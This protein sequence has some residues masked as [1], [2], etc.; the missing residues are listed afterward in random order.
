LFAASGAAAILSVVGFANKCVS[1]L[2]SG[3]PALESL[4]HDFRFAWRAAATHA[5]LTVPEITLAPT[6]SR[7]ASANEEARPRRSNGSC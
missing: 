4:D 5:R 3:V 6:L 1:A 7:P 2:L